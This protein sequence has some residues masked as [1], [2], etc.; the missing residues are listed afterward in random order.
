MSLLRKIVEVSI[1]SVEFRDSKKFSFSSD[2]VSRTFWRYPD[3]AN[4]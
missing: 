2:E 1:K 4:W 3:E